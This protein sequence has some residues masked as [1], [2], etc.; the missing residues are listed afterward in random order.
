MTTTPAQRP[1]TTSG[2]N[3]RWLLGID[4]IFEGGRKGSRA[5]AWDVEPELTAVSLLGD[6]TIDLSRARSLPPE[7]RIDAFAFLRDVDIFVKADWRVEVSGGKLLGDI[8]ADSAS[9]QAG[10]PVIKVTGHALLGDVT[11]QVGEPKG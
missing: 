9:G 10:G 1:S 7:V 4:P 6:V 2:K 5:E 11:V 3:R 8:D